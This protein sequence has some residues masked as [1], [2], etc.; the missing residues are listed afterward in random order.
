MASEK[1]STKLNYDLSAQSAYRKA[2]KK[3]I[4]LLEKVFILV[5][6]LV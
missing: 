2:I 1:L 6:K 4:T 3:E 5:F